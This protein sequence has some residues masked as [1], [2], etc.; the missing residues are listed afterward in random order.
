M[1]DAQGRVTPASTA[2]HVQLNLQGY[3]QTPAAITQVA[4]GDG[5]LTLEVS[6]G[7]A[8]QAWPAVTGYVIRSGGAVVAT[9][10]PDGTCPAIKAPNGVE[11]VYT[12][13]SRNA[14]G[15][16]RGSVSTS[17]W[18]YDAPSAPTSVT[19]AP[20][21]AGDAGGVVSLQI[22]GIDSAQTASLHITSA[23]GDTVDWPVH[24]G[25]DSLTVPQ[26]TVGSNR[27]TTI[28]VTPVSR[29]DLPAGLQGTANGQSRS[30]LGN[31]VG[32]PQNLGLSLSSQSSGSTA[33]LSASGS[34]DLN[35]DGSSLRYGFALGLRG[36]QTTDS[37]AST[38][39]TVNV[40]RSYTVTMCVESW[41]GGQEFASSQ[42]SRQITVNP[43]DAAPQGFTFRVAAAPTSVSDGAQWLIQS[44]P[45][46]DVDNPPAGVDTAFSGYPSD[47]IG[48]DPGI[49]VWHEWNGWK[50]ASAAVVPAA[51]SAPF[52]LA[53]SWQV[54]QCT[55]GSAPAASGTS[56][57]G[58]ATLAFGFK[59]AVY[60]DANGHRLTIPADGTVPAGAVSVAGVT[61]TAHWT[62][63]AWN[64]NDATASFGGTC[65]PGPDPTPTPTP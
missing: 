57:G 30:T 54:S 17:G 53:A 10:G 29:F 15:E 41:Y 60:R 27:A 46:S 5:T 20:V 63:A 26:Y 65:D 8:Q 39:F 12:A 62:N 11:R 14:V 3:P 16:S 6:P 56:T 48:A 40:G 37:G 55:A 34:A 35:G 19:A 24:R 31:G 36:C 47:V 52:Q 9:C 38:Q 21:P 18:A 13:T 61:V 49:R 23:T 59:A 44:P 33:T 22:E 42:V 32:A 50:S 45:T 1:R 51:G 43:D 64:L 2:A 58:G 7:A 28:T 25:V 4:Y